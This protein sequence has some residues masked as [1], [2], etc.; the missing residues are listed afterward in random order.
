MKITHDFHIHTTLS[1]CANKENA[2]I[3]NYIVHAKRL[4][5]KKL[6]FANHYWDETFDAGDNNFYKFQGTDHVL[7]LKDELK[8]YENEGVKLYLGCEGE[9]SYK[10]RSVAISEENA[11]KFDFIVIPNSHTHM[12]MPKEFYEPHKKH[13]EFMVDAYND[14][15]DCNISKYITAMAHPFEAVCCPYDNSILIDLISDDTYKRLFDKQAK[16]GIAFEINVN[17]MKK[18]SHEEIEKM[19]QIRMFKIAKEMGCKFLFGSDAH[20]NEAHL[21]YDN[22]SFVADLLELKDDD[23]LELGR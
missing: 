9:Y 16:K 1:R 19:S 6:G 11:E 2:T 17:S 8:K 13:A 23:I 14:T 7:S 18:M 4:G 3:E 15:L 5:L 22:A 12:S 20:D 21:Y 10:L